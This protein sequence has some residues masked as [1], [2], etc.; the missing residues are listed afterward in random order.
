MRIYK[1]N[2]HY[3]NEIEMSDK[4]DEID[5]G[6]IVSLTL[7]CRELNLKFALRTTSGSNFSIF[8]FR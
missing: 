2:V 3:Q 4:D 7:F 6:I 8:R 5:N 1:I